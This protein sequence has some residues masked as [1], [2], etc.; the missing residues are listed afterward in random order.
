VAYR[1]GIDVG[2]TF[3]DFLIVD[4]DTGEARLFKAPSTPDDPSRAVIDGL[5]SMLA[6]F[7]MSAGEI[8]SVTH[9]TTVATNAV[10]EGRGARVGL[11][12][13][14]GFEHV[15]HL[16][17]GE[18]PGPLAGWVTMIKPD[19]LAAVD[20]TRGIV[21]R[22]GAG[23]EVLLELDEEQA[24]AAVDDLVERGIDSLAI[25]LIN[26][27]AGPAH[28]RRLRD[29]ASRRHPHLSVSISSD[30][31]PEFREY[32]R[33]NVVVMNA[34][35]RPRLSRYL[36][37]LQSDLRS[38]G[39]QSSLAVIR[40]DGGLMT[41]ASASE[42]PVLTLF[43]GPA[44]GVAGAA[45]VAPAAG[46]PD[47]LSFDMGGTSTD[48]ALC[49]GGQPVIARETK[50]GYFPLKSPTID[51]R[52]VG[53]GGGSIAHVPEVTKALR[54]GPESAGAVPG[55]AAYGNG[56]TA[57]TVTDANLV[58]GL[59]PSQLL[60][61]EMELDVELARKAV[62]TVA[63]A[64]GL[65]VEEAAEGIIDVVNENMV[66]AL[67][68]VSVEKGHDPRD[69]ALV[70][71][72]GAGPQHAN[73]LAE[74]LGCYPVIVPPTPG[75]LA[76]L[77]DVYSP[78]RSEF[79]ETF[80]RR[81][82]HVSSADVRARLEQL[83]ESA[84]AWLANEEVEEDVREVRFEVDV[85]YRNQALEIP[86]A[87][88]L[89]L[90][91][92]P[93]AFEQLTERF[94]AEHNRQYGFT[95]S[96][97]PE[98]V[99]LRAVA[100]GRTAPADMPA[101][102][103]AKSD[104]DSAQIGTQRIYHDGE[105][106]EAALYD[107]SLLA[108]GHRVTGPAIVLQKDSTTLVLPGS[109]AETDDRLNIVI[110]R[111][112]EL[113]PRERT[114]SPIVIDIIENAL[115]NIRREMDAV[116]F[117]AAMS[118]VIREEHDSFPLLCDEHGQM[119]AG[120]FGWPLEEFFATQYKLED[121]EPGD[122]LMLNDPYLC[123]GA[124][125]HTPDMLVLRPIFYR[126]ELVG[127]ASQIGNLMDIGGPVPGSMPADS[128]SIFSEG[129]RFPPV[130][131]YSRGQLVQPIADILARNSRTPEITLADTLALVAATRAAEQRV[132]ELCD[133]FGV[134]TYRR[135]CGRLLERTRDAAALMIESFIPE[136]PLVFEDVID[137]DGRGNGPFTIKLALWREDGKAIIDFT[138]SSPQA[139]GP[140]NLF[141]GANMFKMVTG[142]VLIMALDPDILFNAGYNDLLD[143]RFPRGSIVQPE[144]PAPLAN[145][146]HT[147]A[148]I[149][150]V[151]QGALAIQ[152]P[153]LAT[154]AA[155]G[156]SPHFLFS[157]TDSA[158]EFFLFYEI[159]YGGIPGRPAGDGMDVHAWWPQVTSI[160]VEYAE[161]YFPLRI[162][163]LASRMDSG[164][165]GRHRGGN[166]VDKVYSFLE[167][168]HVSIH[169]DRHVSQP[170]GIGGG[171]AAE[172][173]RKI[174]VRRDGSEEEL[175]SKFDFLAVEP[176]DRL[177]YLTAGGGGWGDPLERDPEQVR[178]DV[179]RRFVSI[180]K[181]RDAYGVVLED[182]SLAVSE[183][184]TATLRD[185]MRA[186][187][188]PDPEL[189]D[190]GDASRVDRRA[191]VPSRA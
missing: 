189:F 2:G 144:F 49:I 100:F 51:V 182:A 28:E 153:D 138:G 123:G 155:C 58:L 158:G 36:E 179:I 130:K 84:D 41:V 167:P 186:A 15:L 161:S 29:I 113:L 102:A 117:R 44:G 134:E 156:S 175:P 181:A 32:E 91:D 159:N 16:A 162:D 78:F 108:P 145:R 107:R 104:V 24:T 47:F 75:V 120:Q 7:E 152:N 57:P 43:S 5:A 176:G 73:A 135:I 139:P 101:Q 125:Q 146:A 61:G 124:I 96:V 164:G 188:D 14:E 190:F 97:V 26:A 69:F 54:V 34:Y 80:T 170:W 99:N 126:E 38:M 65:S 62:G 85:R 132:L 166:G 88:T 90:L 147:L 119:L 18:T 163:R 45:Q 184:A 154:G 110:R 142:I 183:T 66:G 187:R 50:L 140:I 112:Q 4:E 46:Y 71:F 149:F 11:L 10:L 168:G 6:G 151:L 87:L 171:R 48:V 77:G 8:A 103:A 178:L 150:D 136:Q 169:D 3:T 127:F 67:R 40:S 25:S 22:T 83:A 95:L 55:P 81:F 53:A 64:L 79:A 27:Y 114:E 56:G 173:S 174:L 109:A 82:D 180:E 185:Q 12:C 86:V 72:G 74:L 172:R 60:G 33:T 76:A 63:D 105:W 122:V 59:I 68:L 30:V 31:L 128:K 177:V 42:R 116:I 137:D 160:P 13:T 93:T 9:G 129:I 121:L 52:S 148:R 98:F 35:I 92:E 165:A 118:T 191:A 23:G 17:R 157:G 131:L 89:E 20:D 21:E 1:I 133:R 141:M 19:P 94:A 115:K 143:I 39:S 111:S 106:L 70:A 37:Q